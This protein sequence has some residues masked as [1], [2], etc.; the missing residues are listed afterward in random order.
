MCTCYSWLHWIWFGYVSPSY[1]TTWPSLVLACIRFFLDHVS[2]HSCSICQFSIGTRVML[3]LVHVSLLHW[4]MFRIFSGPRGCFLFDH[5]SRHC[6]STF[7]FFIRPR[8]FT[9]S[10]HMWDFNSPRVESWPLHVLCYGS[11][12]C[13]N[14]I[15]SRGLSWFYRVE[16]NQFIIEV[17]RDHHYY[18]DWL[19]NYLAWQSN[20]NN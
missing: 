17:I 7:R 15:W 8:G 2:G 12:M 16:Y 5:V 20:N 9:T 10:F 14:F 19:H 4:T 11:S 18:T 6:P 13:R 1:C 3:R